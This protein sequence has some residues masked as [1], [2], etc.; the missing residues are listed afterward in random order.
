M[1]M[2][3]IQDEPVNTPFA[4]RT[5]DIIIS[6]S[7]L[8]LLSP[9][10]LII[11]LCIKIEGFLVK[12]NSG[13]VFYTETRMS[14]GKPFKLLKFRIFKVSAYEPIRNNGDVVH[15]KS[16]EQDPKNLTA[17]GKLLKTFYLDEAPQL[18]N[19]FTGDM[20]LV[21]PRPW[22]PEDYKNEIAKGIF[23]KK[24][25]KAGLTGPV[26]IH[27]RDANKYGGEHKLDNDYIAFSMKH[28][29]VRIVLHDLN[30]LT[31]SLWFT[32]KGQ[33]L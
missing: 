10:F 21:G 4:K 14:Q 18:W 30:I 8:I 2:H 33:G 9:L 25:I 7:L 24:V 23:R 1:H 15:T 16:L 19:V 31:K 22:N 29:G 27:K 13:P 3:S 26:Q 20:S 12:K 17:I 32:L 5:F 28:N 11:I 6:A